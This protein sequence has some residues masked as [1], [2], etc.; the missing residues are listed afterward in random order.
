MDASNNLVQ[1]KELLERVLSKRITAAHALQ[2]LPSTSGPDAKLLET[3]RWQL[4]YMQNDSDIFAKDRA[5]EKTMFQTLESLY[6][7]LCVRE[8]SYASRGVGS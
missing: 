7:D 2:I 4:V 5:Y 8:E 3:V 6:A 1:M